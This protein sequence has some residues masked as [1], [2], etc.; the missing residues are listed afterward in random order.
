[1][2]P[3]LNARPPR[4]LAGIIRR[5]L[6]PMVREEVAGD[7]WERFRSPLHY[8]LD[9]AAAL[10]FILA[11][12]IRRSTNGA[13]LGLQAFTLFASLGG[14]EP[15]HDGSAVP[16]SARAALVTLTAIAMMLLRNAYRATDL[17]TARRA[18]GDML[19]VLAAVTLSQIAFLLGDTPG[20]RV[21]LPWL[22]GG[23][24][25]QLLM[26][27][28][29]RAGVDLAPRD[30]RL[31]LSTAPAPALA[32]DYQRFHRNV[33]FKNAAENGVL[34]LLVVVT[35]WFGTTAKPL[36]AGVCFGWAAMTLIL[37]AHNL[38]RGHSRAM[39]AAIDLPAML[40]FY[41][42]ELDRQGSAIGL[43]WWWY[44]VPLFAGLA[45]NMI[46]RGLFGGQPEL[47]LVGAGSI[48]LLAMLIAR[49]NDDRRR[50]LGE[51]KTI[52]D[53]MDGAPATA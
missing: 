41:R 29:L 25:F 11:S 32:Q 31:A 37:V 30:M 9:A 36:V 10:P 33:R 42:G 50:Q 23:L 49:V 47:A 43:T 24:I 7:L 2:E 17:W 34:S 51:K 46:L 39:P 27:P 21:P 22:I 4:L 26:L 16:M 38:W 15:T 40:A 28:I 19:C 44:F 6:P 12:Q 3:G 1:M 18:L 13:L 5:L 20:W 45:L 14:F 8:L 35:L 48:L 53:R 52:L